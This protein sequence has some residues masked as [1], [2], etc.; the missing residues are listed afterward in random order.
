MEIT[1]CAKMEQGQRSPQCHKCSSLVLTGTPLVTEV[2]H[3]PT[4]TNIS[5]VPKSTTNI[6]DMDSVHFEIS[7][8][9]KLEGKR[10]SYVCS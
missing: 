7:R 6:T 5:Q 2:E 9:K 1:P 10:S 3:L 4:L 8:P